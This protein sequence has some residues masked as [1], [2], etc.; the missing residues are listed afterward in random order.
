MD[1]IWDIWEYHPGV[2][3]NDTMFL[4]GIQ[5]YLT[6]GNEMGIYTYVSTNGGTPIAGWFIMENPTRMGVPLFQ[7]YGDIMGIYYDICIY[8]VQSGIFFG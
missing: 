8:T 3:S 7:E 1:Y 6:M 4:P 5:L 2:L